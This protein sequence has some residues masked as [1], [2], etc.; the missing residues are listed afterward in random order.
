[1][2]MIR[3]M[4]SL[5]ILAAVVA[6]G[7]CAAMESRADGNEAAVE[8]TAATIAEPDGAAPAM[9]ECCAAMHGGMHDHSA[10]DAK[11]C[12]AKMGA[13]EGADGEQKMACCA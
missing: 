9:G 5:L 11:S 3:W 4:N 6:L 8:P 10:G 1:M 2:R 7:G 12:C 13:G